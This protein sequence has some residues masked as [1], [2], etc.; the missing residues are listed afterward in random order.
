MRQHEI[1][2]EG[3]DLP[4]DLT[5]DVERR[6]EFAVEIFPDC[7]FAADDGCRACRFVATARSERRTIHRLMSRAAV[8]HRNDP[9]TIAARAMQ[10]EQSTAVKFGIVRMRTEH[11]YTQRHRRSPQN[12]YTFLRHFTA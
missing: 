2:R 4:D 11:E 10:R 1:G 3:A 7:Y 8:G 9:H 12:R 6:F 5:A